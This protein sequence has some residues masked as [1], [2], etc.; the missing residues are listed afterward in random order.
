MRNFGWLRATLLVIVSLSLVSCGTLQQ[1]VET[2]T[3]IIAA[4][5]Y[6]STEYTNFVRIWTQ[7]EIIKTKCDDPVKVRPLV[8]QLTNDARFMQ[9]YTLF[10]ADDNVAKAAIIVFDTTNEFNNKYTNG[11]PP[12]KQYCE[13]KSGFIILQA[14]RMA[15]TIK[16]KQ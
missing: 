6:D 2:P 9:N 7:A 14:K 12:S 10:G 13:L 4:T 3:D 15:D 1:M 11:Q 8:E 16:R 5:Q